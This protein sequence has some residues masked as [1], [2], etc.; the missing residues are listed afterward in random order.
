MRAER[1]R[2]L[3]VD[4]IGPVLWTARSPLAQPDELDRL[5]RDEDSS[6]QC[7]SLTG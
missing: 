4:D 3:A 5:A 7:L 2:S 1:L 6:V